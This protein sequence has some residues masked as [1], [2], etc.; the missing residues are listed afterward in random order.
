M[1]ISKEELIYKHVL[2]DAL[3]LC[4]ENTDVTPNDLNVTSL[5][6]K[7]MAKVGK[8]KWVGDKNEEFDFEDGTDAKTSSVTPSISYTGQITG[9]ETKKGALRCVISNEWSPNEV[10]YFYI[11]PKAVR[12]L[13]KNNGSKVKKGI[14]FTYRPDIPEVREKD[15]D[16]YTQIEKYRV[17]SFKEVST[18]NG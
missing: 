4:L 6:E 14:K 13:E 16:T 2:K 1:S 18:K 10:D 15:R 12:K 5:I 11:P 3:K 17:K 8:L 9:T 7:A